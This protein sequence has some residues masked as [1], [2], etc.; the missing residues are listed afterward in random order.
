MASAAHV[1]RVSTLYRQS[2]YNIRHYAVDVRGSASQCWLLVCCSNS[3][4]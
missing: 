4:C 3:C 1:S 2:L